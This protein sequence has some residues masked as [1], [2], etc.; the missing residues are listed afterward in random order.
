MKKAFYRSAM[1]AVLC[2]CFSFA[3]ITDPADRVRQKGEQRANDRIDQTIDKG[4]DKIDEGLGSIFKSKNKGKSTRQQPTEDSP[5]RTASQG[6]SA[7]S[8]AGSVSGKESTDFSLYK[9]FDFIPGKHTLFF[10]D[11][12]NGFAAWKVNE[13]DRGD[14]LPEGI[15]TL[16]VAPGNWYKAPRKGNFYPAREITL[17][18]TFTLE[19][20]M[21]AD[22]STMNEMEGGLKAI[23]VAANVDKHEYSMH[24]DAKSQ[25]QLDIHPSDSYL[26]AS[27]QREYG[28]EPRILFERRIDKGWTPG[29]VHHISI[30]RNQAHVTLYVD[31]N[32]YIDLPNGLALPGKYTLLF[33]T[34]LWGDGVYITNVRLASGVPNATGDMSAQGKFVTNTIYFDVNAAR[35]R[36]ESWPSLQS[37][38]AAIRSVSGNVLIVGHTDS[39]GDEAS[40]LALSQRRAE[41]VKA[42]LVRDLGIPSSRL[43]TKGQG[44]THPLIA[45]TTAEG[46]AQNR[47]VEFISQ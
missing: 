47:R 25:I 1:L 44:E 14:A 35:I 32:K 12:S 16:K 45:N 5:Q 23:F 42:A 9:S 10:E 15:T 8:T 30:S 18:E 19:F 11:F 38:A 2:P 20:D 24:F 21:Y 22:N 40:N 4:F 17:P 34:N 3:Q 27:A 33:N 46:K 6:P 28:A 41:S 43:T 36:P 13:W 31:H 7:V 26:F 37:A 29:K 39:D